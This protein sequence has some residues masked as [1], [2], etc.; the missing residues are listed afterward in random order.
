MNYFLVPPPILLFTATG[1]R[2]DAPQLRA[3]AASRSH[4]G[5]F[6]GSVLIYNGAARCG[7]GLLGRLGVGR[8]LK[9]P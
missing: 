9:L 1:P 6:G 4:L 5:P 2:L 7:R 3:N 8:E